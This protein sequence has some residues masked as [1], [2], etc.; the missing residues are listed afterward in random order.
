MLK[1]Y[2]TYRKVD[3]MKK[4]VSGSGEMLKAVK[5]GKNAKTQALG[6]PAASKMLKATSSYMAAPLSANAAKKSQLNTMKGIKP[7]NSDGKAVKV[8]KKKGKF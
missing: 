3:T 1:N 2:I 4:T 6:G 5:S 7:R 8:A